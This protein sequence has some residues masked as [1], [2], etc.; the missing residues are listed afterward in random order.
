MTE[1]REVLERMRVAFLAYR[2][3]QANATTQGGIQ[4]A[5]RELVD[6]LRNNPPAHGSSWNRGYYAAIDEIRAITELEL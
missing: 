1:P 5:L 4:A 3:G 2:Q 6:E